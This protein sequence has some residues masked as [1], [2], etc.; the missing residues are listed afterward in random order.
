MKKFLLIILI[1]CASIANAAQMKHFNININDS[2]ISEEIVSYF[3][4]WFNLPNNTSFVQA[5]VLT[6]NN[7]KLHCRYDQY[8]GDILVEGGQILV[9]S[10]NGYVQDING[11]VLERDIEQSP[12]KNKIITKKN[13]KNQEDAVI[14]KSLINTLP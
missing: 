10:H 12:V 8:I 2:I 1:A 3:S 6:D 7:G 13:E 5:K 14:K 9:H 11:V 4:E